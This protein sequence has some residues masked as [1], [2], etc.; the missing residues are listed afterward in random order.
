MASEKIAKVGKKQAG[1]PK[2]KNKG[3]AKGLSGIVHIHSTNNNTIVAFS[4]VK[5]NIICWESAGTIG[6][7]G[8]KKSTPYAA[9]LAAEKAA[10]KAKAAGITNVIISTNG[11]GQGKMQAIR[12]IDAKGFTISELREETPIPHNGCKPPKKPR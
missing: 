5:G 7:K 4:D 12:A 10:D 1:K 2:K 11:I 3:T 9:G 8:T 6:Y